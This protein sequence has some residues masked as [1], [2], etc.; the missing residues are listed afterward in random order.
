MSFKTI[1]ILAIL[2][3]I[4]LVISV[5]QA[6]LIQEYQ[7]FYPI[8]QSHDQ[9]YSFI[10]YIEVNSLESSLPLTT[11]QAKIVI[12]FYGQPMT[13]ELKQNDRLITESFRHSHQKKGGL[14]HHDGLYERFC[15]YHGKIKQSSDPQV[16]F[17]NRFILSPTL[18]TSLIRF[19]IIDALTVNKAL[20]C[21][22]YH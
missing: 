20:T 22:S 10:P 17:Y 3:L 19:G 15:H 13:I 21:I 2:P 18:T 14:V 6:D 11:P 8:R 12:D 4:F 9:Y 1:A 5:C 7:N 16:S